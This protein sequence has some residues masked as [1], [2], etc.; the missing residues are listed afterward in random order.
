MSAKIID[1][2]A[3]AA[4]IRGEVK[5]AAAKLLAEHGVKPGLATV[6]VGDDPAS[7]KY[8][9]MKLKACEEAG[10]EGFAH[11]MP[12]DSSQDDVLARV[13]EL[14]AAFERAGF[15]D[16]RISGRMDDPN[17][18]PTTEDLFLGAVSP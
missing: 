8:V 9:S 18:P 5:E 14:A 4:D 16:V 12:A 13:Q 2:K 1:G 17:A 3:I 11:L 6:L 10:F 15:E 7:H